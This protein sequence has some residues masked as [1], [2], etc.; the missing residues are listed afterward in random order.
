[1]PLQDY[2]EKM[3][4]GDGMGMNNQRRIKYWNMVQ[5]LCVGCC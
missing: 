1:M 2:A 3:R 4:R 5:A